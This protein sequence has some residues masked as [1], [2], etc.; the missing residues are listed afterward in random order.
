MIVGHSVQFD[1]GMLSAFGVH[2]PGTVI[3]TYQLAT[4]VLPD[5]P[6]Y[7]LGTVARTL[8]VPT[9][10]SHRALHDATVNAEVFRRLV[11]Q[12][13]RHDRYTL[14]QVAIH[15][16]EAG[17]ATAPL[18][19]KLA[20][21]APDE[22]PEDHNEEMFRGTHEL[23]FLAPRERP[24]PLEPTRSGRPVLAEALR[25]ALGP[26]GEVSHVLPEYEHRPQQLAM[27]EAVAE[28]FNRNRQLLVEAGTGTGKSLAYLLPA[29]LHAL[30]KGETVVIS[31]NTLALQDQL[32]RKDIPALREVLASLPANLAPRNAED[33]IQA[34]SLKGRS[35]YLC[36]RRWFAI[37]EQ[38]TFDE[39][40]SSLRAKVSL[41]LARTETGDRAELRLDADEELAW[42]QVA[43]EEA[44]CNPARCVFNQRNQCF[45]FRARRAAE[46]AHLVVVNHALLLTDSL[47]GNRILPDSRRLIIDE[48]HHL[49]DQATTHYEF[50]VSERDVNSFLD[51]VIRSDA[52]VQAGAAMGAAAY[53]TRP[54]LTASE[55]GRQRAGAALERV[56]QLLTRV[57][58]AR[59]NLHTFFV[60]L[61]LVMQG[62]GRGADR[63][64]RLTDHVREGQAWDTILTHWS[65]LEHTLREIDGHL[66]WFA[67]A[68]G[69]NEPDDAENE[70]AIQ[71]FDTAIMDILSAQRSGHEV[72]ARLTEIVS[73]PEDDRVYWLEKFGANEVVSLHAAPLRVSELLHDRVFAQMD[74][75]VLTSATISTDGTF[76]YSTDH[77]GLDHPSELMVP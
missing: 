60:S 74:T 45:L 68:L 58:S 22:S 33:S 7:S 28:A 51:A 34:V 54:A 57:Q 44:A 10:E 40:E 59:T 13:L 14:Q 47:A 64:L 2:L 37:Q 39:A 55:V 24:E 49:E 9:S 42:R 6:D 46:A 71:A 8:D 62:D 3:D 38:P 73:E 63:S 12:L 20:K 11:H 29:A 19:L 23:A 53:L 36:L 5:L 72:M 26:H 21:D 69:Q 48:A 27:A 67:D 61:S 66:R 30:E 1:L 52:V 70:E 15:A 16:R 17:W 25:H 35:N 50:S 43:A 77:L 41:W 56:R 4:L 75:T 18:L 31:T 32:M 76:S 65:A